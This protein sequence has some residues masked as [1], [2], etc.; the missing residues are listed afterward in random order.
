MEVSGWVGLVGVVGWVCLFDAIKA[1]TSYVV[2]FLSKAE[3]RALAGLSKLKKLLTRWRLR[4]VERAVSRPVPT[5]C[6][7]ANPTRLSDDSKAAIARPINM[8]IIAFTD[9]VFRREGVFRRGEVGGDGGGGG[10]G[11]GG[12]GGGG[13]GGL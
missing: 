4:A 9:V 12:A 6:R 10:G 2:S 1:A 3:R 11:D 7:S 13:A 5:G 8:A